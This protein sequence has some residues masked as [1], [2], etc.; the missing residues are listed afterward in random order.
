M[1]GFLYQTYRFSLDVIGLHPYILL[2]NLGMIFPVLY[3]YQ[4]PQVA[5][6]VALTH[7]SYESFFKYFQVR[8]IGKKWRSYIMDFLL[9]YV[10]LTFLLSW[11][12]E[13]SPGEVF[14]IYGRTLP[15]TLALAR[16]GCLFSGCCH[17]I[18]SE[19]GI[20][21]NSEIFNDS[22]FLCQ[23][24]SKNT[25]PKVRVIP[26]QLFEALANLVIFFLIEPGYALMDYAYYYSLTRFCL[27]LFRSS[28][29]QPRYFFEWLSEDQVLS[30]IILRILTWM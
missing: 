2:M 14:E 17:G 6:I 30:L 23:K 29:T 3:S 1:D 5:L 25:D 19:Y 12:F 22:H 9:H 10:P 16:M 26:T 11:I 15:I 28:D 27:D 13:V 4:Q 8:V 18:P 21:Y 7:L 20:L 24:Y